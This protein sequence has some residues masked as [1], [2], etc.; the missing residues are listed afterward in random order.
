M[1][2]NRRSVGAM[3]TPS[4]WAG[5]YTA[6]P[7]DKGSEPFQDDAFDKHSTKFPPHILF[8]IGSPLLVDKHSAN[9]PRTN[10]AEQI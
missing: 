2:S 10:E 5:G 7:I 6:N 8:L 9:H 1:S 4:R 3:Y